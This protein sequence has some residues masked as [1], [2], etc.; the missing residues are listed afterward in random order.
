MP[1]NS[2]LQPQK[3]ELLKR[4]ARLVNGKMDLST[5]LLCQVSSQNSKRY[6]FDKYNYIDLHSFVWPHLIHYLN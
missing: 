1:Q 4:V 6:C 3:T 2:T 5:K